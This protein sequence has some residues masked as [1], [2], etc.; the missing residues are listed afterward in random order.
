MPILTSNIN[1]N[2]RKAAGCPD[3]EKKQKFKITLVI[4]V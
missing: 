2:F 1:E 4:N 3:E